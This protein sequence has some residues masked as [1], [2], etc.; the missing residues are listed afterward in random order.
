[1]LEN[2]M[3]N[4]LDLTANWDW[5]KIKPHPKQIE[6]FSEAE[7][8]TMLFNLTEEDLNRGKLV[9][10]AEWYRVEVVSYKPSFAKGDNSKLDKVTFK[11]IQEGEF[12]GVNLYT[13]FSE[14]APGFVVP[15]FEA[16]AKKKATVG[17]PFEL[18]E[19]NT[20]GKQLDV[21]VTRGEYNGKPR[22]EVSGYRPIE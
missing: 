10:P 20:K 5:S 21:Y 19:T 4:W 12:K 1:M 22:N 16:I 2:P 18:N 9:P 6:F 8:N 7:S 17:Q 15:F 3:I 11:I 13:Q 14:K